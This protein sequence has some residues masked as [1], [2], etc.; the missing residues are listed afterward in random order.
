MTW[1]APLSPEDCGVQSMPDASP[2]KWHLAHTTWFF[3][4][5]LLAEPTAGLSAV[6]PG[7]RLP[8]QLVLQ[9]GRR[10]P[11]AAGARAAVAPVAGRGARLPQPRRRARCCDRTRAR[12]RCARSRR[13]RPAPRAAAPGADPH[14]HQARFWHE[15][16]AA[17]VPR[18]RP[19]RR[20]AGGAA[21]A[22]RTW[23]DARRAASSRS[24][25]RARAPAAS[26]SRST[27]KARGTASAAA[28]R[29]GVAPGDLR[30]VPRVHRRRRL[31]AAR[32]VALRRLGRGAGRAAGAR[33]STGKRA[34]ASAVVHPRRHASQCDRRE[35]V[36]HVSYYEADA[37]ARW[38]G[39]ACRPRRSGKRRASP[40]ADAAVGEATSLESGGC[41][42]IPRGRPPRG[43]GIAQLFGDVW[44]WTPSPYTPYPGFRP[45]PGA[46]GEYNGKFMCNQMVLRGG[47]CATP[48]S[49]HPREL[50][51]L[52]SARR[53]LADVGLPPS[54]GSPKAPV[55]R[56]GAFRRAPP[57]RS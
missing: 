41:A 23:R 16:A 55:S 57:Y 2:T 9:R 20:V 5:F 17:G 13:A 24:A 48:R 37:Y 12:R 39:R 29:A 36:C 3:E 54:S 22:P 25:R 26:R 56:R 7:V 50:P 21:E 53:A 51:Q 45:P 6:R 4:T 11:R 43:D 10:A 35:P 52:L 27:T 49:A 31:P 34:T 33:R 8:L 1:R 46:L 28:V 38:A 47:S 30:R 44:E 32:A 15:P 42:R 40:P 14:R 18:R 19:R